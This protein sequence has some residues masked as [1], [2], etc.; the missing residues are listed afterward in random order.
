[1]KKKELNRVITKLM[2]QKEEAE[3]ISYGYEKQIVEL[4][5]ENQRLKEHIDI[6]NA[7]LKKYLLKR[8]IKRSWR[9]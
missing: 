4:K 7:R 8:Q 3:L 1:M 6:L 2:H 9:C 5:K